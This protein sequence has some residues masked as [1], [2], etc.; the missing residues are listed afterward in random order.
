ME[1]SNLPFNSKRI[2][3]VTFGNLGIPSFKFL[4]FQMDTLMS[5]Q[6][7]QHIPAFY[8]V[9]N[10]F[11]LVISVFIALYL[12]LGFLC[13]S[14]EKGNIR[15]LCGDLKKEIGE[16]SLNVAKFQLHDVLTLRRPNVITFRSY[17]VQPFISPTSLHS[18]VATLP[19]LCQC[20]YQIRRERN[21]KERGE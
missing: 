21:K 17:D 12:I 15:R 6:N 5:A 19:E 20:E 2:S 16:L 8:H 4:L 10:S 1:S 11:Q 18:N 13:I 7:T 9:F 3:Y 14:G